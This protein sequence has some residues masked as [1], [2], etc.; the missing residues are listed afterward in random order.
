[1][2]K[3][4]EGKILLIGNPADVFSDAQGAPNPPFVVCTDVS[5]GIDK[6]IAEQPAIIAIAMANITP[7]RTR[8]TIASLHDNTN[9]KILL[10][11]RMADEPTAIELLR[12]SQNGIGLA[13]DY[14]ICPLRIGKF[15]QIIFGG[16]AIPATVEFKETP[17]LATALETRIRQ[18]EKL[19]TEDDLTGLKN[20]R[21]TR[22]FARQIIE[23]A[24]KNGGRV[25]VLI[26]DIDDLKHYND[27]YGHAAGD[28]ALKMAAVLIQRCCRKHDI[29]GRLGGDEFAAIFWDDPKF[30]PP[31]DQSERRSTSAEHPSEA[32]L[33]A[34]RI[35][36]ELEKTDLKLESPNGHETLT[37]SGGLAT[38]NRDGSTADELFEKADQA[39]LEAKRSGKNRVYLVGSTPDNGIRG[40][41]SSPQVGQSKNDIDKIE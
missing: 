29:V 35:R 6:A 18:L 28:Q 7:R 2:L 1:M 23:R 14:I 22:E 38:L 34:K 41:A 36:S 39:L 17:V 31:P 21:Y 13:D 26:F 3:M 10:L 11:A 15:R 12:S 20:R 32:I 9:A 4:D 19:A 37:I 27:V 5:G 8:E 40:Q 33:I 16:P 25:T 24:K 30:T